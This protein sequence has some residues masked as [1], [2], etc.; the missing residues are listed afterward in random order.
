MSIVK[1]VEKI[2][3]LISTK[4]MTELLKKQYFVQ[5]VQKENGKFE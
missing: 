5:I 1:I 4:V 3:K 2:W